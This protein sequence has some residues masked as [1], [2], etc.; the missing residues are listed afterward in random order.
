MITL[1]FPNTVGFFK[2]RPCADVRLN[3]SHTNSPTFKC[4]VDTGA[5]YLQ[6]PISAC[7]NAGLRLPG[8]TASVRVTGATGNSTFLR[9]SHVD[10]EIEGQLVRNVDMLLDPSNL[11]PPLAGRNVLLKMFD[12]GFQLRQWHW[13][14]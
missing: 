1:T 2:N 10:L 8:N 6:L 12:L 13:K 5:D 11:S 7:L 4:I 3:P 14:L 9:L